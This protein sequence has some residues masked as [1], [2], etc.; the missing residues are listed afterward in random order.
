MMQQ[1]TLLPWHATAQCLHVLP[2]LICKVCTSKKMHMLKL[3]S[4]PEL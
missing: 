1:A 2:Q 3:I 4:L